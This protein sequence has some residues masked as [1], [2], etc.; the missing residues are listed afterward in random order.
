[1]ERLEEGVKRI[2]AF[3]AALDAAGKTPAVTRA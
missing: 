2:R 1:M 3:V